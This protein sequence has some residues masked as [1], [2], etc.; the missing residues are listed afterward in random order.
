MIDPEQDIYEVLADAIEA[1]FGDD[2]YVTNDELVRMPAG[3]DTAVEIVMYDLGGFRNTRT[4][5]DNEIHATVAMQISVYSNRNPGRKARCKEVLNVADSALVDMNFNRRQC[6]PLP[7]MNDSTIYRIVAKY[8][9]IVG[10]DH[11][12]Y[13]R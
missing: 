2:V 1:E 3:Y 9:A 7:N 5:A 6:T 13:R 12:V 8:R 11:T 4:Q 10:Q